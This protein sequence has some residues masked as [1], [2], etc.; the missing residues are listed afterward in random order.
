MPET[1]AEK[2]KTI[3]ISG[4]DHQGLA[5]IDP[6]MKPTYPCSRNADGI[7]RSVM[8]C[9]DLAVEAQRR[10]ADVVRAEGQDPV[11]PALQTVLVL[12]ST[13]SARYS[14]QISSSR[15]SIRYQR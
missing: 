11:H 14:S 12:P 1:I 9:A 5:L 4:V 2:R 8:T 3:G 10:F 15:T 7:P 13:M 6:K